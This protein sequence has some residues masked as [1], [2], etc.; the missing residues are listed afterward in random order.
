MLRCY[1]SSVCLSKVQYIVKALKSTPP[2]T[3]AT[4]LPKPPATDE[5]SC[6]EW[7]LAR[8]NALTPYL[9]EDL[10]ERLTAATEQD[11]LWSEHRHVTILMLALD[12]FPDFTTFLEQPEVLH[13]SLVQ[14]SSFF[15][16]A[17]N[18][19]R[20]YDGIVNKIGIGPQGP[21]LM[22]LF[23]APK[24]HEDDPLRAVLAALE[25]QETLPE[26]LRMGI[27]TGFVFAGDVGTTERRE[28]TVM[29][30]AV[31]L[32]YRLMSSCPK[33]EIWLGPDTAQH[34]T[35]TRRI[36]GT[37]GPPQK[38]KGKQ[39]RIVP[40][41]VKGQQQRTSNATGSSNIPLIGREAE[42][43]Q[44]K[45]ILLNAQQNTT[46][47]TVILRGE[48]G[49]GKSRL[50]YEI[51]TL[52][53]DID[54]NV[55]RGVAPSYGTH[56]PYAAWEKPLLSLLELDKTPLKERPAALIARLKKYHLSEWAALLAPMMGIE[57]TPSPEV[58]ALTPKLRE[59]QRQNVLRELWAQTAK[60][61]PRLL[62]LENA[63]W[64]PTPSQELLTS[65]VKE[66]ITTAPLLILVTCRQEKNFTDQWEQQDSLARISLGAL[67]R[68]ETLAIAREAA[69]AAR[70]PLK[71]E[72]WILKRGGGIPL[73][74]IEAVKAL[75]TS[76][77][78]EKQDGD[79]KLTQSLEEAPLPETT[80]G[81][82]QSRIDQLE[83][84]SRHLL[85]AATVVGEQM[86]MAMLVAGYGEEPR[87]AV[88]RRLPTLSPLGFIPGDPQGE[89]LVFRQ[90]L[91][92]EV[93][94]RGLPYRIRRIIHQ[95]LAE[96]LDHYRQQ[97]TS[98]WLILLAHHAFEGQSCEIAIRAN[99]DL[100]KRALSSYLTRQ[101]QLAFERVLQAAQ[102]SQTPPPNT[103]YDAHHLLAETLTI[104][105]DYEKALEHLEQAEQWLPTSHSTAQE[106]SCAAH[107]KY[108]TAAILKVQGNYEA[109]FKAVEDGLTL[110]GVEET[111]EGAQL[112][113]MGAGLFH[114]QGKYAEEE[115]WASHS[116]ILAKAIPG[117]EALK[118]LAQDLYLLAYLASRQGDPQRALEL[119]QQSLEIYQQ[120][121]DLLGEMDAR[122]NLL[123]IYLGLSQWEEAV[124]HGERALALAQRIRHNEGQAK[125]A[126]NL[127]EVYR[128]QGSYEKARRAYKMA[129]NMTQTLGLTYG[130]AIMEN[131]LA[132]IALRKKN[133]DEAK[134]R[135][136]RAENL[137]QGIGAEEILP[138]LYRHRAKLHLG[139]QQ[140]KEALLWGQRSLQQAET[141]GAR[142]ETG[143]AHCL[144]AEVYIA[145]DACKKAE[146][147]LEQAIEITEDTQDNYSI[148]QV[149]VVQARFY[150]HCG[151]EKLAK[152][153]LQKA[154]QH[155][156]TLG[157][158][159][160]LKEA[161][162]LSQSWST[163]S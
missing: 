69:G 20:R 4:T 73:F 63:Q 46:Q 61:Q 41:I 133:W 91:I 148:A 47:T 48:A 78:L 92:R 44:V 152:T 16:Q 7:L 128:Y 53:R 121:Q 84:P 85:R 145:L 98:N 109:A 156:K 1:R 34:T 30:D 43:Q 9:A 147:A 106:V 136:S 112:Y 10:L 40:F 149:A 24:A 151:S 60:E 86:T 71:V 76:G 142:Q 28:Y 161:K 12:N 56:L 8:L 33:G 126:A 27:N 117:N 100:G 159:G 132:A 67:S 104:L 5:V 97:V 38:L 3:T 160:D 146:R 150:Q 87:P 101:A 155:F 80:Y 79:W 15:A 113:L 94:Y 93:A 88:A 107:L 45:E 105:G 68:K 162:A 65:L 39:A 32:A 75:V 130:E 114:R 2:S 99:L 154:I 19:I 120:L 157:A 138:E 11:Q 122:N 89:T 140:P 134:Q 129:L 131:N 108:H 95:R 59:I 115:N 90:P 111:L 103:L 64:M 26:P 58:T 13:T 77:L 83:P 143:Y 144:L 163:Q 153:A 50:A 17:R 135:L 31:N 125:V 35:I 82:I 42:L 54:V 25:M 29:G 72:N 18:I 118:V 62:I 110:P 49:I 66:Q 158:D 70:L 51:A 123:L 36:T 57:T 14:S 6:L 127:G 37:E 22:A 74:T 81:M 55:H 96:Y 23:G 141:Q 119:G 52:A 116:A 102:S 139:L 124:K 137:L 21:Y